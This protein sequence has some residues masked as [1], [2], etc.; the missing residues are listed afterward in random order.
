[1]KLSKKIIG[2]GCAA[3][4][5]IALLRSCVITSYHLPST[6]MENS[7]YKGEHILVNKWSYG[8]R[9]PFMGLIG[10]HR[11]ANSNVK[12]NDII[13]FNN[14][15]NPPE[16][17]INQR[18]TF[19]GRCIG[20]PGDT[21][22]IDSLYNIH[23][24]MTPSSDR[25]SLYS[26]PIQRE[27]ELQT[28]LVRL[29]IPPE[30]SNKKDS[31][32]CIR[33]F[34][35][36]EYYLLQQAIKGDC[37]IEPLEILHEDS[38]NLRLIV[39]NSK[40][41]IDVTPWNC[42]LLCNTLLLHEGEEA[43]VRNDSLFVNGKHVNQYRFSKDYHWVTSDNSINYSDSRLFGFIPKDHIIGRATHIWYSRNKKRI[44]KQIK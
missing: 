19:I 26:Y 37:W 27:D 1:M 21:L 39:P 4:L 24:A 3:I 41:A 38:Y 15:A 17:T 11:W 7:L 30:E 22:L 44:G 10:Y 16:T 20:L 28:L 36:Y 23:P 14:P 2:V 9:L 32:T 5:I 42:T 33:S 35:R 43:F 29:N 31:A 12:Q 34:S 18:E 25:K 40:S 13:I 8:L 6:G